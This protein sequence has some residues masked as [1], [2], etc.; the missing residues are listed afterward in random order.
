MSASREARHMQASCLA[1]RVL[2]EKADHCLRGIGPLGIG[3]RA[4]GTPT[5]P[6]VAGPMDQPLLHDGL[7]A[8]VVVDS[9]GIG[10]AI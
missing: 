9:A 10:M 8:R 1:L 2:I 6:R 7:P 4:T 5:R 3:K